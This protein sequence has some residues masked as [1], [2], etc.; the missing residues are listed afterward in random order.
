MRTISLRTTAVVLGVL[1]A[2][3]CGSDDGGSGGSTGEPRDETSASAPDAVLATA[4]SDLG[5]IVV[6]GQGRTVYVFD[7]DTAG[8][9]SSACTGACLDN[10]PPVTSEEAAPAVDGVTGDVGTIERDDGTLQ[11]TLDGWP[12]YL[13][14]GDAEPG[15]TTGQGVQ[16]VWWVV[17]PDGAR[18]T[19]TP[20]AE[21]GS[22]PAPGY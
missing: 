14:A 1:L 3:G 19:G 7:R 8:A 20:G 2:T 21:S 6:D 9:G 17:G 13:F 15:D 12:L 18:I 10:W 22:A 5:E 11:V 16:G 4:D